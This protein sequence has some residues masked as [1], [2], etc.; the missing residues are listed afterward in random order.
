ME[1][2]QLT[3]PALLIRIK[4]ELEDIVPGFTAVDL[5]LFIT[6]QQFTT[7]AERFG[8]LLT[9]DGERI[10][11]KMG[12]HSLTL[13]IDHDYEDVPDGEET[14]DESKDRGDDDVSNRAAAGA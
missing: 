12:D 3:P 6:P 13:F 7:I 9:L 14:T 5:N 1:N 2:P 11:L 4:D 10:E 8:N